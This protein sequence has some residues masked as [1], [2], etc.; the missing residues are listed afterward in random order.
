MWDR[1]SQVKGFGINGWGNEKPW[2]PEIEGRTQERVTKRRSLWVRLWK[3]KQEGNIHSRD[4]DA[5]R[6]REGKNLMPKCR[7][8]EI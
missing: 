7:I 1:K 2:T 3:C 5:D 6:I 4:V 8:T